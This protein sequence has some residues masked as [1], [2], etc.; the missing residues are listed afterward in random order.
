MPKMDTE[1]VHSGLFIYIKKH[2]DKAPTDKNTE[3][4]RFPACAWYWEPLEGPQ[5]SIVNMCVGVSPWKR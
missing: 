1:A 5:F 3:F 4:T 2:F